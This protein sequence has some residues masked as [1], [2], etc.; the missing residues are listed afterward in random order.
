[1]ITKI[2]LM[3]AG[4]KMGCRIIDNIKDDSSFEV[5]CVEVGETGIRNLETRGVSPVPETDAFEVAD[6]IV[7]ALPDRLIGTVSESMVPKLKA[8]TLVISLDPAA[9]YAGVIPLRE[10]LA[11]FVC[12]PCHPPLF[13]IAKTKSEQLD[14]FG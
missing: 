3:G 2:A 13:E 7:L 6:A 9:A 1:M 8:G 12:H 10:D 11:Y 4:G 14:W 5:Y